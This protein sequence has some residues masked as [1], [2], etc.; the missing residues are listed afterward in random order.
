MLKRVLFLLPLAML[1]LTLIL[2]C[3]SCSSGDENRPTLIY[4][5]SST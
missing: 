2:A 3:M 5:R 1:M 4:F